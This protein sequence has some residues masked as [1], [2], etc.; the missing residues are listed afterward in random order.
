[1]KLSKSQLKRVIKEELSQLLE[2]E[3]QWDRRP[4]WHPE[5]RDIASSPGSGLTDEGLEQLL[6]QL[7]GYVSILEGYDTH[8]TL[9]RAD[10]QIIRQ[11]LAKLA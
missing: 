2:A 8:G 4:Y 9:T 10:S 3:D 7:L 1:M 5:P 11:L 6:A